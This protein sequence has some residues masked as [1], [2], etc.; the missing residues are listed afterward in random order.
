M[1]LHRVRFWSSNSLLEG[2]FL[3][4]WS[5]SHSMLI[6]GS[7][8]CL[9]KNVLESH[10]LQRWKMP[11]H[12][13]GE[14]KWVQYEGHF[15]PHLPLKAGVPVHILVNNR[16]IPEAELF[17]EQFYAKCNALNNFCSSN[18]SQP[19]KLKNLPFC[20][21]KTAVQCTFVQCTRKCHKQNFQR[22]NL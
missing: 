1:F 2:C 17:N 9:Q 22:A 5:H 18:I 3:V 4:Y 13:I 10:C 14:V 8:A 15:S 7:G 21:A 6:W 16:S 20:K 11:L 19:P 12:K